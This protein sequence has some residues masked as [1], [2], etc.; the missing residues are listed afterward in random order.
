MLAFA[1]A[2]MIVVAVN[3]DDTPR[4][5]QPEAATA[6]E[7]FDISETQQ[8][9]ATILAW[10]AGVLGALAALASLVFVFRG[11]DARLIARLA[12][13]AVLLGVLSIVVA[14]V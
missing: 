5:D 6:G 3:P 9:I 11:R 12:I 7:C 4:C 14:Q 8:T 1:A 13:P 10:P 2:V